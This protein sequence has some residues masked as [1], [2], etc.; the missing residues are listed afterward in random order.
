MATP[1]EGRVCIVTG[2]TSGIGKQTALELARAGAHV[3]LACRNPAKG[4]AARTEIL[5]RTGSANTEVLPVDL[6]EPESIRSFATRFQGAHRRL[7]VLINNA[8]VLSFR[9][10]V[11]ASG[12]EYTFAVNVLGPF[13][14]TN[15]LLPLLQASAPS[16]VINVG[17]ATHFSGRVEFDN[18][19]GERKF[20]FIRAYSNSKLEI[21]LLSYELARRLQGSGVTVNCVH[22]GTI[23]TGL[24]DALPAGFGFVKFFMHSPV[25]G[26]APIM[27]LA[28]SPELGGAS[29]RY[30]DRLREA[31]SSA[32]SYDMDT[33]QRLWKTCEA[34]ASPH[35]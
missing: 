34:L 4:E 25:V 22:P 29:G 21:L 2:P 3:I 7:D 26:A 23:R 13:L 5:S 9:R 35:V 11:D 10:R 33:A 12:V 1:L 6:S 14:L 28:A 15:L 19:Q 16:R 31:R 30:F 8:G 17:S 18:L 32:A 20:R 27:R 24:Y